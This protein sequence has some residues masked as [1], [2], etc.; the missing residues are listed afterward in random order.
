MF[1]EFNEHLAS[2]VTG[3]TV[4]MSNGSL[5]VPLIQAVHEG[6]GDVGRYLDSLPIDR[7][8]VVPNVVSGL[9]VGMLVRRGFALAYE[10]AEPYEA[11]CS[12][13][14]RESLI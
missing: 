2:G 3:Y 10:W 8:V 13:Y 12:M 11:L 9:L 5:Y 7:V 14:V 1:E 6:N 4:R